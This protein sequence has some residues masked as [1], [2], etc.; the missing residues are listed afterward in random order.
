M[1]RKM[2]KKGFALIELMIVVAI[3]GV[4]SMFALPAYQDYTKRTYI[5]E[6]MALASMTK[7][8]VAEYYSVNGIWPLQN[9]DIGLGQPARMTG[10]AIS[11][12]GLRQ[13]PFARP[14]SMRE[15]GAPSSMN[16]THIVIYFN[17]KVYKGSINPT[18]RADQPVAVGV[19]QAIVELA[20]V[21]LDSPSG[22]VRWACINIQLIEEKW[23]PSNCR[24]DNPTVK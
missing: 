14:P 5:S 21:Y 1:G 15:R 22:S 16:A 23:L 17:D 9:A 20:P 7:A 3:I 11:G 19:D 8:S 2:L 10:Q 6:G 4:L 13:G 18:E 24:A 12:L